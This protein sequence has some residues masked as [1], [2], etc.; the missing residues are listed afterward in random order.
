MPHITVWCL[1]DLN[2]EKLRELHNKL[3]AATVGV[4]ELGLKGEGDMLNTFPPDMMKYGLGSEIMVHVAELWDK[5]ERTPEV[6]NRLALELGEA[7]ESMFPDAV[8]AVRLDPPFDPK[9]GF[10]T[11][12]K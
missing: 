5:P 11:N 2:E 10:W 6:R 3:V 9:Q 12:K 7:V 1:P 4:K 8:V